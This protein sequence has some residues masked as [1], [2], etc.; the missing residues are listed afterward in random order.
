[1]DDRD[2]DTDTDTDA[3]DG[4]DIYRYTGFSTVIRIMN[5]M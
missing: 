1:M 3:M 4:R 2:T 5:V